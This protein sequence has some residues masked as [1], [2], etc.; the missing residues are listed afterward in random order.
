M[1][2]H[3][4]IRPADP[5]NADSLWRIADARPRA[6][7]KSELV[8]AYESLLAADGGVVSAERLRAIGIDRI[9]RERRVR[10]G[11]LTP[12]RHG[13]FAAPGADPLVVSAVRAGGALACVS[14]LERLGVWRP[15][16]DGAHVRFRRQPERARGVVA[17]VLPRRLGVGVTRAIDPPAT[18]IACALRCQ[19]A[20]DAVAVLDS[21]VRLQVIHPDDLAEIG[22][23]LGP[24][25]ERLVARCHPSSESGTET[26]VRLMLTRLRIGFRAQVEIAGVGRTDFLVGDRLI[27]EVDGREHHAN[28]A[29]FAADRRR[30]AQALELG[31]LVIRVTWQEAMSDLAPLQRRVRTIV[32]AREHRWSR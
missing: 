10:R 7:L 27:I 12:L 5:N 28:P 3:S 4:R 20:G 31:Y 30:D 23:A 2:A 17:H 21:A 14:A 18:A 15:R 1:V 29:A 19:Q 22:T 24:G 11:A 6:L 9:E 13:W 26:L 32:A 25:A 8:D 16:R